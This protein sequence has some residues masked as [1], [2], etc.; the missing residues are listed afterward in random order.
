MEPDRLVSAD[1]NVCPAF[2][3]TTSYTYDQVVGVDFR[4]APG[5]SDLEVTVDGGAWQGWIWAIS[6]DEHYFEA[7]EALVRYR[8]PSES[9]ALD[10]LVP[11]RSTTPC[12]RLMARARSEICRARSGLASAARMHLRFPEQ[13]R[14][15]NRAERMGNM[16]TSQFGVSSDTSKD[17]MLSFGRFLNCDQGRM[18]NSRVNVYKPHVKV[19]HSCKLLY[20][21][22]GSVPEKRGKDVPPTCEQVQC[23]VVKGN[24]LETPNGV[25]EEEPDGWPVR[26]SEVIILDGPTSTTYRIGFEDL[27]VELPRTIIKVTP[28][29]LRH[30]A[31]LN[32][33]SIGYSR[34]EIEK[35]GIVHTALHDLI[36]S[37]QGEMRLPEDY[38]GWP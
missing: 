7:L 23:A 18:V 4:D 11:L 15:K 8:S 28:V 6:L 12:L 13:H 37:V 34:V 31:L 32:H 16:L 38:A 30:N 9:P 22:F 20:A 35:D 29:R 5:S 3:L 10:L 25:D 21:A 2:E 33:L 14:E 36:P 1:P 27:V 26:G 19:L 17:F 24:M